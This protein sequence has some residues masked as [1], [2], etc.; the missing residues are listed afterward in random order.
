LDF[1]PGA[2]AL[3]ALLKQF[4]SGVYSLPSV[5]MSQFLPRLETL[6]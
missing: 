2:V 4:F 1:D 5:P 3:G 6:W